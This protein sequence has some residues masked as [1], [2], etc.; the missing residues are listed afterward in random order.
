M[1]KRMIAEIFRPGPV[2]VPGDKGI[3][4]VDEEIARYRSSLERKRKEAIER[5]GEKWILHPAHHVK[6]K[7]VPENTLGF[8]TA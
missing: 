2:V 3:E 6:K 1:F 8:K 4:S 5:M 7:D